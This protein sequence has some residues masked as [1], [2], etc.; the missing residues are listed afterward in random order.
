MKV[1]I[2]H[3]ETALI[4]S[5]KVLAIVDARLNNLNE[6]ALSSIHDAFQT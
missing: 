4:V 6:T 2:G 3:I 5:A 1:T